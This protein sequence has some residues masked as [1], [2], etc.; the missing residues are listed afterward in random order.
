M[1]EAAPAWA[2]ALIEDMAA[3]KQRL[4]AV[5][6]GNQS[7]LSPREAMK[8]TGHKSLPAFYRWC[9][10]RHIRPLDRARYSRRRLEREI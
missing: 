10:R 7:V 1:S 3:I 2:Q 9:K 6:L 4:E 5:A 8:I